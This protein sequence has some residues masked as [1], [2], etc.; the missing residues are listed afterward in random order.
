MSVYIHKSHNVSVLIY[1]VV[2]TAKYRR[3]VI[4]TEV[5]EVIKESC[6]EIEKRYDMHFLEIGADGDHVHFLIQTIPMMLPKN[7]VQR[8]KSILAREVF[9]KR[10]EVKK[11]LWGGQF[12]S[13]GYFISTVGKTGTETII[14]QYVKE[15][16]YDKYQRMHKD[17]L[18]L[19]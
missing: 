3:V 10:P 8:L 12:W 14:T 6:K 17:Q 1:H 18:K 16:G 11:K 15:Q 2:C 19:M 9:L 4:S 7:M 5:D 13:D